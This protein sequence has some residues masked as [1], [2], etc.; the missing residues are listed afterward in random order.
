MY[1]LYIPLYIPIYDHYIT[2]YGIKIIQFKLVSAAI[3]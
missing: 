1:Q 3:Y 2:F